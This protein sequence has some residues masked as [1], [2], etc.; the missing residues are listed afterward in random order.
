MDPFAFVADWPQPLYRNMGVDSLSRIRLIWDSKAESHGQFHWWL[1]NIDTDAVAHNSQWLNHLYKQQQFYWL[2][3][4]KRRSYLRQTFN[5][6]NQLNKEYSRMKTVFCIYPARTK[7]PSPPK[8]LASLIS[9][10]VLQ[11]P[12]N[13][14]V[15]SFAVVLQYWNKRKVSELQSANKHEKD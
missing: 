9:V 5:R 4:P 13:R 14:S 15:K 7:L 2:A 1:A 12:T 8:K 6:T 11:W 3:V 10:V